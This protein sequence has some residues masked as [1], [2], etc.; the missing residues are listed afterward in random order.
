M[1]T[2]SKQFK[3]CLYTFLFFSSISNIVAQSVYNVDVFFAQTHVQKSTD[4]FF[5]LISDRSVL[6]KVNVSS[7]TVT[8]APTINIQLSLSGNTTTIGLVG[9]AVLPSGLNFSPGIA[10]HQF[11]DSYTATIPVE[12]VKPGLQL[13]LNVGS[14]TI[15]F[16][17]LKIGAPNKLDMKMF[18]VH[19]FNLTPGNYP[20]GWKEELEEKL[21]TSGIELTRVPN[22]VFKEVSMQPQ[23]GKKAVR[24]S[25]KSNYFDLTGIPFDGEQDISMSWINA[26]KLAA[27]KNTSENSLFYLNIYGVPSGGEGAFNLTGVGN[28]TKVNLLNHELGHSMSLSHAGGNPNYPYKGLQH[29]ILPQSD[30]FNGTHVGPVWGYDAKKNL[31]IPPTVQSNAVSGQIGKYKKE[32]M[33][34]GGQLDQETGFILRHFSDYSVN[35]MK[36][37]LEGRLVIWNDEIGNYAKWNT[38]TKSYSTVKTNNGIQYPLVRNTQVISI[39]TSVCSTEPQANI[40]YPPI[41]PYKSGLIKL[42]DP[43]NTSDRTS[44]VSLNYC[45][46]G[47]CDVSVKVTQGGVEKFYLMPQS[48]DKTKLSTDPASFT[49]SAINLNA[50]DGVVTKVELLYTPDAQLN[51]LPA[52]PEILYTYSI[53]VSKSNTILSIDENLFEDISIFPNPTSN[54]IKV[55]LS[56]ST[57]QDVLVELVDFSGKVLATE[58]N[59]SGT[60][61]V[62]SL[63]DYAT[64]IY[65]VRISNSTSSISKEV[66]KL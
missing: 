57:E 2:K 64:G 54:E 63:A 26:L 29:G 5:K 51:G 18:D 3:V 56:T 37:F 59:V 33:Q 1:G 17:D 60:I 53:D 66:V 14:E 7:A 62:F 11:S 21:P 47:G 4:A 41:G 9:P 36:N 40:V 10:L 49:T 19:F 25:S 45:P 52:V 48:V 31:F 27:G 16:N 20:V 8:T 55:D 24:V 65:Q 15:P 22:I 50:S 34:Q 6:V 61:V 42:F 30:A 46:N 38:L 28:G 32:P 44:A 39:L 23:A 58:K 12:W 13:T 35:Q 43:T